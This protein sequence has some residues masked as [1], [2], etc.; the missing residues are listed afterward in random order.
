MLYIFVNE[1]RDQVYYATYNE[2]DAKQFCRYKNV[3][4]AARYWDDVEIYEV[5]EID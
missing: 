1:V 3:K 2:D 5:K 4:F